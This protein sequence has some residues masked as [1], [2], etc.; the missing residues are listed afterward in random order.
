MTTAMTAQ[1]RARASKAA[2]ACAIGTVGLLTACGSYGW[3]AN[4]RSS[5]IAR[6]SVQTVKIAPHHGV[7]AAS[8]TRRF[9]EKLTARGVTVVP[10]GAESPSALQ[11]AVDLFDSEGIGSAYSARATVVCDLD[12]AQYTAAEVAMAT[13]GSDIESGGSRVR[14]RAVDTALESVAV[15]LADA[16][17]SAK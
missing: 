17:R 3:A 12:G 15:T 8:A 11:C 14:A 7:E 9:Q 10:W 13:I 1:T 6:V 5:T 2:A 4:A 16:L